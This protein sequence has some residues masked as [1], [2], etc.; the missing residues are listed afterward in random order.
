MNRKAE[1]VSIVLR[2]ASPEARAEARPRTLRRT[3]ARS[4]VPS[5]VP[6]KAVVTRTSTATSAPSSSSSPSSSASAR[7]LELIHDDPFELAKTDD[8]LSA[9]LRT[10]AASSSTP[11]RDALQA[12]VGIDDLDEDAAH[13]YFERILAH[14][15]ALSKALAR[16]IHVRVAGLDMMTA[17][18]A[19]SPS[20]GASTNGRAARRDSHPI[21]VTPALLERAL[22][23]ATLD[24]L[25]GL[26]QRAQFMELFRHELRQRRQRSLVVAYIDLDRFKQVNDELGHARGDEVLRTLARVARETLRSGDVLARLGG[27]EFVVLFLDVTPAEAYAALRRLRERFE[28]ATAELGTSF[29]AGIAVAGHA[30]V[31]EALLVRADEAMYRQKRARAGR[32]V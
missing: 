28:E 11:Y 1:V 20:A 18:P 15:R 24:S 16:E 26:P 14:R 8:D 31:A 12:L 5:S 17:S 13:D 23:K 32:I 19:P 25:T 6:P 3:F 21:V 2:R 29:S 4:R 7:P 9:V 22:E 30:E 10:F 27:D